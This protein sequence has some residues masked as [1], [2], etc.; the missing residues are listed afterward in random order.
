MLHTRT[1]SA[2]RT[3]RMTPRELTDLEAVHHRT[4]MMTDPQ[5]LVLH[6]A[7]LIGGATAVAKRI[8]NQEL[9]P[10]VT[11]HHQT[12]GMSDESYRTT[13]MLR[14]PSMR[15]TIAVMMNPH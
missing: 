7:Q 6:S 1:N 9:V 10:N 11:P 15:M 2:D 12:N 3:L 8:V 14:N 5:L 4:M 13:K